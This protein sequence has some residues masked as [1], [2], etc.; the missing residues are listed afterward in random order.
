MI[1]KSIENILAFEANDQTTLKEIIHPKNDDVEWSYSLAHASLKIGESSL[2]HRLVNQTELYFFLKGKGNMVVN[3]E[4]QKIKNGDVVL[5]PKNAMQYIEN[6]GNE[7]LLF[8]CIVSPPWD[9]N[10]DITL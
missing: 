1:F 6:Q 7:D 3:G 8:L 2:P 5:V 9:E 4:I 10:D